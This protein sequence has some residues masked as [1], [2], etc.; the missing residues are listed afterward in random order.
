MSESVLAREIVAIV[1][2][3]QGQVTFLRKGGDFWNE[4]GIVAFVVLYLEIKPALAKDI[5]QSTGIGARSLLFAFLEEITDRPI[6]T[7]TKSD[8]TFAS[9]RKQLEIDSRFLMQTFG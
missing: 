7:R 2:C 4:F 3:D 5:F 9:S 6:D 1:G 8:K